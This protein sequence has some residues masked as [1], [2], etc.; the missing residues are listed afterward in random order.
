VAQGAQVEVRMSTEPA[1]GDE[2][3]AHVSVWTSDAASLSLIYISRAEWSAVVG[4]GWLGRGI[5]NIVGRPTFRGSNSSDLE[6]KTATKCNF[7]ADLM[8]VDS[9]NACQVISA[10]L[11]ENDEKVIINVIPG[12]EKAGPLCVFG[13]LSGGSL[14]HLRGKKSRLLHRRDI[15][16][17]SRLPAEGLVA[18]ELPLVTA[19]ERWPSGWRN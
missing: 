7:P 1:A 14:S 6:F 2:L 17:E 8:G 13:V 5:Y 4:D 9:A 18:Q 12:F 16:E 15:A 10:H 3:V 11:A 19:A